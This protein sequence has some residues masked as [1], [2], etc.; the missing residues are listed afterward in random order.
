MLDLLWI[1]N[2][3]MEQWIPMSQGTSIE[4]VRPLVL[5]SFIRFSYAG[6][7]PQTGHYLD[8]ALAENAL[9]M[10]LSDHR[11]FYEIHDRIYRPAASAT[12]GAS[13]ERPT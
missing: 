10:N 7:P 13:S 9:I 12:I 5:P 4:I 2:G 11:R 3:V 1:A 8:D 6:S